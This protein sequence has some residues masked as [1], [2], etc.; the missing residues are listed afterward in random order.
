MAMRIEL[1]TP[2]ASDMEAK[3]DV[4]L[5]LTYIYVVLAGALLTGA[6]ACSVMTSARGKFER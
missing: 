2:A 4:F 6:R 3:A 1:M 5:I